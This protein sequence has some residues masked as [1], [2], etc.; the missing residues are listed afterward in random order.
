[1]QVHGEIRTATETGD[2]MV[3]ASCKAIRTCTGME[4]SLTDY[5]VISVTGGVDALADVSLSFLSDDGI[6]VSG[7][8]LSTDVVE[9]SARAFVAAINRVYRIRESG[10]DPKAVIRPGSLRVS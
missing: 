6:K 10:E 1:M 9:A 8:G 2:G 7:R 4:G 3:D 5:N